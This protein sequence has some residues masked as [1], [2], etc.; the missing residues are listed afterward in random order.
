MLP[1]VAWVGVSRPSSTIPLIQSK[2]WV[3][4]SVSKVASVV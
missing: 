3:V 4:W 1:S 2:I